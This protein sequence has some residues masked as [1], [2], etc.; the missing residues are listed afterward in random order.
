LIKKY[1]KELIFLFCFEILYPISGFVALDSYLLKGRAC[2]SSDFTVARNISCVSHLGAGEGFFQG[3]G[4][5]GQ[6]WKSSARRYGGV[7]REVIS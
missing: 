2:K 3:W 6:G 4:R 7:K 1:Y 5:L